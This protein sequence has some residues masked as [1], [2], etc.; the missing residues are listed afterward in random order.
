MDAESVLPSHYIFSLP[1]EL[2]D[3]VLSFAYPSTLAPLMAKTLWTKREQREVNNRIGEAYTPKF[4]PGSIVTNMLVCKKWFIDASKI[5]ASQQVWRL[6]GNLFHYDHMLK[7]HDW[8]RNGLVQEYAREVRDVPA[9]V[10]T[11]LQVLRNL[12]IAEIG[13]HD[14][15]GMWTELIWD[16]EGGI[17]EDENGCDY[18]F[19]GNSIGFG[20]SFLHWRELDKVGVEVFPH[21]REESNVRNGGRVRQWMEWIV[22]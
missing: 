17:Y 20:Y 22:E 2:L 3:L 13:F 6:E 19:I 18:H 4:Y 14:Q 12:R 8:L 5:W 7:Y 16:D 1:Q 9:R 11:R 21:G 15:L 10:F